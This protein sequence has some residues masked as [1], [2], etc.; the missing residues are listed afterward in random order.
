MPKVL[1]TSDL[2]TRKRDR[3][4]QR[5]KCFSNLLS[6]GC[7]LSCSVQLPKMTP[8]IFIVFTHVRPRGWSSRDRHAPSHMASVLETFS[9]APEPYWYRRMTSKRHSKD[10]TVLTKPVVSSAYCPTLYWSPFSSW[11]KKAFD[12][13][14]FFNFTG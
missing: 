12:F 4:F 3:D 1:M 7:Q 6:F 14:I 9:L 5:F 10:L 11:E 8:K 2:P 13:C